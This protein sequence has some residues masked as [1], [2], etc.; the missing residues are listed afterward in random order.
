MKQNLFGLIFLLLFLTGACSTINVS[1]DFDDSVDFAE[2]KT[3]SYLGWSKNSSELLNDL[4]KKRIESAFNNEFK[5][6]GMTY[7]QTGGDIEVSLYLVTDK[8][9]ATTAYTDYYGGYGG[10]Y[11][12]HPWGWGR[13]F[14]TTRYHQYDYLVGT[15]VCD[16]VDSAKKNLV[17]QGVGSGTVSENSAGRKEKIPAAVSKIMALYPVAPAQ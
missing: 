4:D 12:G 10:Y 9:T 1:A 3:Y 16:V 15:L 17:W 8:K 11:F 7:V 13:G 6:R 5:A 2:F 14:A